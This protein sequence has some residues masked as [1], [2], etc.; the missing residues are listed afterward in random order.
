MCPH[1]VD[2]LAATMAIDEQLEFP[3]DGAMTCAA[4]RAGIDD[5]YG[6]ARDID[7]AQPTTRA[8]FWYVS[9]EKLEPRIGE[10]LKEPGAEREQPLAIAREVQL[11]RDALGVAAPGATIGR[12]LLQCSEYRHTVRRVQTT[13][14]HPYAEIRDNLIDAEMRP[15]DMLRCKLSFFGCTRFDPRSDKW[16]RITLFQ[17]APLPDEIGHGDWDRWIWRATP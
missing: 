14:R 17:G 10:R 13:M 3:I 6:W 8:K 5:Q 11:L 9:E 4:L 12:F 2:P 15:I 1:L 16:L 7:F